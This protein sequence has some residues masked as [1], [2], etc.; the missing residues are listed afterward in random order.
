MKCRL[1]FAWGIAAIW[2]I[3]LAGGPV[4]AADGLERAKREAVDAEERAKVLAK[5]ESALECVKGRTATDDTLKG[6]ASA[7]VESR[8]FPETNDGVQGN[9]ISIYGAYRRRDRIFHHRRPGEAT[10]Q[11]LRRGPVRHQDPT[12]GGVQRTA[13][14]YRG[15]EDGRS[16]R[17]RLAGLVHARRGC[18][19]S[20]ALDGSRGAGPRRLATGRDR[21]AGLAS[22]HAGGAS[23]SFCRRFQPRRNAPEIDEKAAAEK[24]GPFASPQELIAAYRQASA[25]QDWRRGR[26]PVA[27]GTGS[28]HQGIFF[29]GGGS[30]DVNRKL[31]PAMEKH[32]GQSG[33]DSPADREALEEF[34][35]ILSGLPTGS[36][37]GDGK[38]FYE[39][40]RKRIVD[41]PAF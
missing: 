10:R 29:V 34:Q 14:W 5:I 37:E 28:G 33:G 22:R 41:I 16:S 19:G 26:S 36:E 12:D 13:E 17:I 2:A 3:A 20:F 39:A 8:T 38:L 25:K 11:G 6:L 35:K 31:K 24:A 30:P 21:Q 23:R 18:G 32:L 27:G 1:G 7:K 4:A 40:F 15:M 9:R